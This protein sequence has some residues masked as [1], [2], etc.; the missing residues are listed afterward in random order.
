MLRVS[1]ARRRLPPGIPHDW[2]ATSLDALW[3]LLNRPRRTPQ[4]T[5]EAVTV[6]VRER[7]LAALK[8]PVNVERL[9]RCDAVAK[10]EI[11]RRIARLV[12]AKEIAA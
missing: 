5:I 6:A 2:C 7:G 1:A 10:A 9:S 12:A 3:A 11:N 4:T 8:E